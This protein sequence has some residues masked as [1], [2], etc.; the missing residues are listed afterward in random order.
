MKER[1]A[2]QTIEGI[3][4]D[5]WSDAEAKGPLE[6]IVFTWGLGNCA[7]VDISVM[8]ILGEVD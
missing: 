4:K 2:K 5:I 7:K 6:L 3:S 8:A 1:N